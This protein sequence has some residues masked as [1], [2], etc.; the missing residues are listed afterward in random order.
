M[1]IC[2][3]KCEVC[4]EEYSKYKCP[5]CLLKYCSLKCYNT[6]KETQCHI[7][8]Q[9]DQQISTNASLVNNI[10]YNNNNNNVEEIDGIVGSDRVEEDKLA[11]VWNS[12]QIQAMLKN[13]VL[14]LFLFLSYFLSNNVLF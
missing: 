6:H 1:G 14:S 12:D 8:V 9:Q 5:K 11:E 4:T 10:H 13:N 3:Y 2:E 7:A